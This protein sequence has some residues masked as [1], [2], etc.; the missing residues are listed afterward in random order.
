MEKQTLKDRY[1]E[2]YPM[3][4]SYKRY[5]GEDK[6]DQR[7]EGVETQSLGEVMESTRHTAEMPEMILKRSK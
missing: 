1:D 3:N 2:S 4:H 5:L 7:R 6:G